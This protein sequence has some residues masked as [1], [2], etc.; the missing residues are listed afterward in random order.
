[1]K[2]RYAHIVSKEVGFW[3]WKRRLFGVVLDNSA[4]SPRIPKGWKWERRLNESVY[5]TEKEEGKKNENHG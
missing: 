3:F 5:Y 2:V 4:T 1:M